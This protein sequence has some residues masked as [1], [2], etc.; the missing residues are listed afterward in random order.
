VDKMYLIT[1]LVQRILGLTRIY[2]TFKNAQVNYRTSA[3]TCRHYL[4]PPFAPVSAHILNSYCASP[5][6]FYF[7]KIFIAI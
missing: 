6:G 4:P 2:L 1:R 7:E 3:T 5:A